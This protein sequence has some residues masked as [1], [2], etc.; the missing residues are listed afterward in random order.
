MAGPRIALIHALPD[1]VEPANTAFA[2]L[3]PEAWKFNLLDD[4]LARDLA[5]AGGVIT[6]EINSRIIDLSRY[7]LAAGANG[8]LYTCSA[9]GRSI[10]AAGLLSPVPILRPNEAAVDAALDAGPRIALLATFLPTVGMMKAEVETRAKERNLSPTIEA[11][12]V[13]G[14]LEAL[15]AGRAEEHDA[16]IA[17]AAAE[18]PPVDS[19][20][21]AQFSMTRAARVI[22]SV[23]G[24]Q[25]IT[26]PGSAIAKLKGLLGAKA[27]AA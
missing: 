27:N 5:A 4:A 15:Q 8:I 17:K 11:R 14:A 24:R 12:H 16:L 25:V 1:S 22:A 19:V 21:L 23:A 7:A 13:P 26:T 3:W 9:F 10:K 2:E 18:L 20:V 6:M